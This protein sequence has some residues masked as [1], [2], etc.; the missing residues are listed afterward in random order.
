MKSV[1]QMLKQCEGLLGTKDINRWEQEFLEDVIGWGSKNSKM[2]TEK[3][4]EKLLEIYEKHF[5]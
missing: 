2:L 3:Q 4:V 5:A 1:A